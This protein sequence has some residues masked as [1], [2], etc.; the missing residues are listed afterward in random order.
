MCRGLALA[1]KHDEQVMRKSMI[2]LD[3]GKVR[4]VTMATVVRHVK[5]QKGVIVS[6]FDNLRD[7]AKR[8]A[9]MSEYCDLKAHCCNE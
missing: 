3:A 9:S 4:D 7:E 5:E 2:R 1:I 8:I 6:V